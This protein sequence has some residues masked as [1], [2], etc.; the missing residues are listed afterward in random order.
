V[1]LRGQ[2]PGVPGMLATNPAR[3]STPRTVARQLA[4]T[5]KIHSEIDPLRLVDL[6][7]AAVRILSPERH[8]ERERGRSPA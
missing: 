6:V 7:F 3:S 8:A 2:N 4:V 5:A 1:S